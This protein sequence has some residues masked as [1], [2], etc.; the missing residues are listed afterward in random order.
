M[1]QFILDGND[2]YNL[3]TEEYVCRYHDRGASIAVYKLSHKEAKQLEAL[4]A[5]SEEYWS[6]HLAAGTV[7]MNKRPLDNTQKNP[8]LEWCES[9]YQNE[10]WVKT[11]DVYDALDTFEKKNAMTM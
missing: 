6:A 5:L 8:A 7:Y 3:E 9:A 4:C 2:M 11:M 10:C 1:L